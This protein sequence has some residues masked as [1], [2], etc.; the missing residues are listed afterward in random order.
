MK[1]K[2]SSLTASAD[3]PPRKNERGAVAKLIAKP[4]VRGGSPSPVLPA[5][6]DNKALSYQAFDHCTTSP[7]D[8]GGVMGFHDPTVA[9]ANRFIGG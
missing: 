5:S 7:L 4:D 1:R 3:Q 9:A 2:T 6:R 8:E